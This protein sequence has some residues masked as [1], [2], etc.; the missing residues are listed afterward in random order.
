MCYAYY[1][2]EY[3]QRTVYT[4]RALADLIGYG[5]RRT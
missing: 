4:D 5:A 1:G 2:G 3:A